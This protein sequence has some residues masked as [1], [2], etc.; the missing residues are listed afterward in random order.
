MSILKILF[1]DLECVMTPAA[2]EDDIR[3][4]C[5]DCFGF[6]KCDKNLSFT[7]ATSHHT[8]VIYSVNI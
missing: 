3:S 6:C 1:T 2:D 7:T 8:P 5:A 4:K